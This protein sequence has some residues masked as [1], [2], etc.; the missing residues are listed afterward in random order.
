MSNVDIERALHLMSLPPPDGQPHEWPSPIPI[1][2][3][4]PVGMLVG[5][6]EAGDEPEPCEEIAE[7]GEAD[8]ASQARAVAEFLAGSL[9]H[10]Q[11]LG[12]VL[13][14]IGIAFD[15]LPGCAERLFWRA[16]EHGYVSLREGVVHIDRMPAH[17]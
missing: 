13:E 4:E 7:F 17:H 15:V 6:E 5:D 10:P 11:R 2:P 12:Y 16:H 3:D 8:E 1:L 14:L 9:E